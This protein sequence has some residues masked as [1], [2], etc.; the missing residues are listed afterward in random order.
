MTGMRTLFVGAGAT[1]GYFGGRMAEAGKDVS[2]LVRP[3]RAAT[4]AE[5]GLRI[6]SPAGESLIKPR[7]LTADTLD[8]PYDVVVLAVKSYTLQ[9]ALRDAA[10]AIGPD[11]VVVPLLNGM[12]HLTTLTEAF[13]P[14]RAYG[15]VCMIHAALD[16]DGGVVQ[17][18]GIHRL[19]FGRADGEDDDRVDA[20]TEALSGAGFSTVASPDIIHDMWEK[21]VFLASIGAATT[22]FRASIGEINATPGGAQLTSAI[23]AESTAIAVA[24]GH[25]PRASARAFLRAGMVTTE[26]TTSSM[27]RD[28][29]AGAP[30]EADTIL[31]DFV[32]EAQ[33][34]G[35]PAPLLS[36]AYANLAI[37]AARR[38]S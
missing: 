27:Y 29:A 38:H 25:P 2:F 6:K 30:V 23:A 20:V 31:G 19:L 13:G 9:D 17:I 26:R 24:A 10:P 32:A 37:Y 14:D 16:D 5:R 11:T 15:G 28:M 18:N 4:L 12:R 7:L 3:R 35:V 8:G 22:L 34:L 1:G 33:R 36:A 21:W